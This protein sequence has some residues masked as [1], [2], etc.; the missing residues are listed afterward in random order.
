MLTQAVHSNLH[1]IDYSGK[2]VD[3]SIVQSSM[4]SYGIIERSDVIR[5]GI[6]MGAGE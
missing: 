4:G 5:S 6:T 3:N 2:S 1:A